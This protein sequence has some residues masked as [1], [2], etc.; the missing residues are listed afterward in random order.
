[1]AVSGEG[2]RAVENPR[3]IAADSCGARATGVRA[4]FGLGERPAAELFSLRERD[5]VF[6]FLRF[7]AEFVDVICAKRIVRGDDDADG[8]VDARKFFDGDDIFD[9]SETRAAVF[10]RENYAEQAEFGEFGDQFLREMRCFVPLHDV[11]SDFALP[12]IRG[13]CGEAV[14][15][16]R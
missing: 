10:F 8:A 13:L 12:R 14:A 11:R 4:G 1:M 3:A 9:V 7:G 16:R 6:L 5:D 2:F 15:V